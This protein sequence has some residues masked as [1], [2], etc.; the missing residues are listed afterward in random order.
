MILFL[1]GSLSEYNQ[2]LNKS[3]DIS[4]DRKIILTIDA[5]SPFLVDKPFS[6]ANSWQEFGIET[7]LNERFSLK[8]YAEIEEICIQFIHQMRLIPIDYVSRGLLA[9]CVIQSGS[10]CFRILIFL[11]S[12]LLKHNVHTIYTNN[13]K[14]EFSVILNCLIRHFHLKV[15]E[16]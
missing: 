16:L 9:R 2:A 7:M 10:H 15:V 11:Y 13:H 1:P 14:K 5:R 12:F 4:D 6:K 3:Q 8:H